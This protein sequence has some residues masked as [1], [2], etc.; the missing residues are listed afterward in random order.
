MLTS[1]M[2]TTRLA[3][4]SHRSWEPHPYQERAVAFLAG[5]SSAALFLDPGL[6][7]TSIVLC[8][9]AALKRMGTAKRMLVVAPLRVCQ[10]VWR[11]EGQKWSQFRDLRFAL[12]HGS[13]KNAALSDDTDIHLINPEGVAWLAKAMQ[14]RAWPYDTV[15]ID[16][17]T[18]FKN[19]SAQRHKALRP[20]LKHTRRRWGLTGTPAPNGY[21]DL[22]GQFLMLDDGAA[23]GR[24]VTHYRSQYFV[25]DFNGYDWKLMPNGEKRI[26]E[27]I[28]PYVLRMAAE[29]YLTLPPLIDDIRQIELDPRSIK[30]YRQMRDQMLAELPGGVVTAQ[31]A[32]GVA[33]KLKQ[34]AGGAVYR[35]GSAAGEYDDPTYEILHT[36]KLDAVVDMVEELAGQPLLLAYEYTHEL[37]RL[38]ERFPTAPYLGAGVTAKRTQEIVDAWNRGE[39]PLLLAHPKSAGHGLNLQGSGCGHVAWFGPTYDLELYEQFIDRVRRQGSTAQR[40]VNH[41]FVAQDTIDEQV[42][43]IVREKG[44]TQGSLLARL[45]DA[46][47]EE[48]SME[49]LG[50]QNGQVIVPKGWG[51]PAGV[52]TGGM[53][54]VG[55]G[56][57]LPP[58]PQEVAL[59]EM[60]QEASAKR[61]SEPQQKAA[62]RAKIDGSSAGAPATVAQD[63]AATAR[64]MFSPAV[65][66]QINGAAHQDEPVADKFEKMGADVVQEAVKQMAPPVVAPWEGL[67]YEKLGHAIVR[68]FFQRL[69]S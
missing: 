50:T 48:S 46:I 29:D 67:D 5:A 32:G 69:V 26:E 65:Q 4:P 1:S 9:F 20:L 61:M 2:T 57:H 13:K 35:S 17:I 14:G 58:T 43:K 42:L 27:R 8:A 31:N 40:V 25:P 49:K 6:G 15:V 7:K 66:A 62:I 16:E 11:Q 60:V 39:V 24:F 21:L 45:S 19:Q 68:A 37:E 56:V 47:M 55:V 38:L 53:H 3:P 64:S 18:K 63:R 22:F 41:I 12:L 10:T 34:M 23:L 30:T 28:R 51:P 44:T 59:A 52:S 36:A 54:G 33:N